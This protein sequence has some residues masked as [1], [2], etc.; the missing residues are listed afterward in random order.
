MRERERRKGKNNGIGWNFPV[1]RKT[2]AGNSRTAPASVVRPF[3]RSF[4][5]GLKFN[6]V[7]HTAAHKQQPGGTKLL[8]SLISIVLG[9]RVASPAASGNLCTRSVRECVLSVYIRRRA[10]RN[11]TWKKRQGGEDPLSPPR[12]PDNV[13]LDVL[14]GGHS[15]V[16]VM[17]AS[18]RLST[19]KLYNNG[20]QTQ[21]ER[22]RER[23]IGC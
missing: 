18:G 17:S 5:Q 21:R 23:S 19:G 7:G 14:K 3:V 4:A 10:K 8:M 2:T 11:E 9:I 13:V 1:D 6:N 20:K 15:F 16:N 22:E 12:C